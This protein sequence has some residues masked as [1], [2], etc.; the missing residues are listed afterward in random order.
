LTSTNFTIRF[1]DASNDTTQDSWNI[2]VALLHLWTITDQYT[3]EVEFTGSSNLQNW[4]S[5]LWQ[6]QSCWDTDQVTVNIQLYNFTLGAY[7]SSGN[8]HLSYVSSATSNTNELLSKTENSSSSDFKNSTGNW[9]LKIT[10]VKSTSIQFL[11]K[12]DWIDLR[13]TYSTTGD[14]IPF[15]AWQLYSIKATT[16]SGGPI[17]YAY[18]SIYANGTSIAFRN[19]TNRTDIWYNPTS[20]GLRLDASGTIQ[21][22][23]NSTASGASETFILYAVVGSEVGKKTVT[24]EIP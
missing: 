18:V 4:T 20:A 1:K 11:M 13:T 24:Q 3:A 10:G 5:L 23:I 8:G 21:L 17:P 16:T 14:T 2:D 22:E 7:A 19:A 9:R 6:I 15:N 12:I